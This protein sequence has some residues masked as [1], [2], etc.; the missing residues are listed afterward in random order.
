VV[1]VV[2]EALVLVK[3]LPN[4]DRLLL[5]E[6]LHL[7]GNNNQPKVVPHPLANSKDVLLLLRVKPWL[8]VLLRTPLLI[9]F[10]VLDSVKLE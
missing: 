1:V 3:A 5:V 6:L 7:L 2:A 10:A 9:S 8:S 4:V